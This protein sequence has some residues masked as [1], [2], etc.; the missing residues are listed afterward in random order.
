MGGSLTEQEFNDI[1][2]FDPKLINFV[3]TGTYKGDTTFLAKKFFPNVY[4][5]ELVPDLYLQVKERALSLGISDINFYRGNST[6]ILPLIMDSISSGGSVFFID[7]HISG[8]GTGCSLVRV[9][10][11]EE[12]DIIMKRLSEGSHVFIVDD[13]RLW[14]T[15]LLF[16]WMSITNEKILDVFKKYNVDVIKT[17]IKNDRFYIY[18]QVSEMN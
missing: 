11:L 1:I 12:L 17:E 15:E 2:A 13:V 7:A 14:T 3:E 16:D 8:P 6:T 18:C 10:L 4:T 5:I 9:P